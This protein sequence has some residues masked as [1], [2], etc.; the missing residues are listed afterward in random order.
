[1]D[2][3]VT[4]NGNIG[5]PVELFTTATGKS[6]AV[7]RMACTPRFQRQGSWTDDQTIWMRV[8]CWRNLADNVAESINKGDP[9]IVSG[10]L[11]NAVW[12]DDDGHHQR[13]EMD[14]DVVGHDLGRGVAQFRRVAR[15][16][17]DAEAADQST[18]ESG[19][20]ESGRDEAVGELAAV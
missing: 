12:D 14:A 8:T 1:M 6:R 3:R 4:I 9:V 20:H 19:Q 7:F 15:I 13:L 16:D 5:G 10:K 17:E 2:A 18:D 11:R